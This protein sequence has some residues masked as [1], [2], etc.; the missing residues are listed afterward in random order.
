MKVLKVT[1]LRHVLAHTNI[2]ELCLCVRKD[3]AKYFVTLDAVELGDEKSAEIIKL[4]EQKQ[5]TK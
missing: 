1:E 3:E 2:G 5:K 4:Y